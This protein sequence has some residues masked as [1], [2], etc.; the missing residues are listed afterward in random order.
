MEFDVITRNLETSNVTQNVMEKAFSNIAFV[1]LIVCF[2]LTV[3]I[4]LAYIITVILYFK[5]VDKSVNKKTH[6]LS[7]F[8]LAGVLI[9]FG[10]IIVDMN[11]EFISAMLISLNT[12]G[13]LNLDELKPIFDSVFFI[14]FIEKY[15]TIPFDILVMGNIFCTALYAGAEGL[16]S[17]FKTLKVPVGMCIELPAIKRKR[18]KFIF[19]IWC[20]IAILSSIYTIIIGSEEI[21]FE[22]ALCYSGV[23]ST[24]IILILADRS[25]S[26]LQNFTSDKSKTE[27]VNISNPSSEEEINKECDC[28]CNVSSEDAIDHI[29]DAAVKVL[30][31]LNPA[32]DNS[33]EQ[34]SGGSDL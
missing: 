19:L 1:D 31:K 6:G 26:V 10:M 9:I 12:Y 13:K 18:I 5:R 3:P 32:F 28:E 11:V 15:R 8:A 27:D 22:V 30:K 17:S 21:R 7:R 16:I 23:I 20:A 25:P 34:T 4:F 14:N 2:I 29:T 24:L 33:V